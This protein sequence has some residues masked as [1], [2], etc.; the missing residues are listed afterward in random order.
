MNRRL[1][2][3]LS[4]LLLATVGTIALVGYV[5]SAEARALEDERVVDVLVVDQRIESGTKASDAAESVRTE[6]VPAKVRVDGAVTDLDDLGDLVARV[7]LLP[8]EQ[9][10]RSRFAEPRV[11]QRGD[12]P[13]GLLEITLPL[14]PARALGG[15]LAPGDTVGVVGSFEGDTNATDVSHLLFHKVLVTSVQRGPSDT[16]AG[17]KSDDDKADATVPEENLLVSLALDAPSAEQVVFA[18]EYGHIWL[19]SE[20]SDAPEAG[21]EVQNLEKVLQ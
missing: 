2:G 6:Q 3:L 14:E 20:P 5:R 13:E 7:D 18:A 10:A 17:K 8:G 16:D 15:R 12:V 21:T 11:V 19:L 1:I 9:I 4:S